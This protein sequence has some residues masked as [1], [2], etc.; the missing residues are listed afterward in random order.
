MS[1]VSR[2][3]LAGPGYLSDR[4]R[5]LRG[6][7]PDCDWAG[8]ESGQAGGGGGVGRTSGLERVD[9]LR[10]VGEVRDRV[11]K[12]SPR[13]AVVLEHLRSPGTER[14]GEHSRRDSE[15]FK[16]SPPDPD[17]TPLLA[18]DHDAARVRSTSRPI[19]A[20]P[21]HVACRVSGGREW[22]MASDMYLENLALGHS[23]VGV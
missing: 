19:P 4:C 7:Q 15:L 18:S 12:D 21:I 17:G 6:G 5:G 10:L 14:A 11:D 1:R 3:A 16:G 22:A 8:Q 13:L 2:P 20:S 9:I 23:A